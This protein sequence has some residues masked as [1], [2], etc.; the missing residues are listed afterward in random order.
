MNIVITGAGKGIG[1]ALV[2]RFLQST[3]HSVW[4]A[5]R[6]IDALEAISSQKLFVEALDIT[7]AT[8]VE[9]A[10]HVSKHFDKVDILIHNAGVLINKSFTTTS[11]EE[12]REILETNLLS[13]VKINQALLPL[14]RKSDAAHIVHIGSMGGV[15]GSSKFPGLSAYSASKAALANLTECMAEELKSEGIHVN[16]LALGAVDTEML[17]QA[18]P[19]YTADLSADQIAE[20]IYDFSVNRR[21]FFN[22]KI[23]PVATS[24]P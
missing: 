2:R 24:T 12:W 1:M 8:D 13:V 21:P 9:I 3:E 22:G 5:S 14:L 11:L 17:R 19:S 23:L 20:F 10:Q 4:A 16:C 6:H 7:A 15:Q 18:F